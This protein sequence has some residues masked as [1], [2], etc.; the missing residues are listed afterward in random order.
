MLSFLK[1]TSNPRTQRAHLPSFTMESN[2][3]SVSFR[4]A[5]NLKSNKTSISFTLPPCLPGA[6]PKDNTIM[7][8][9]FHTHPNQVETFLVTAGTALFQLNRRLV[10]VAAGGMI[11]IPRGEYH[12]FTNA[13]SGESMTL[14]AWYDPPDLRREERFFRNLCG[15]LEDVRSEGGGML[16][17]A[18]V[19]QLALFAWEADMMMCAPN[20]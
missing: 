13:S 12:R 1:A 4:T 2:R 6:T 18:S 11:D 5:P 7:I 8:P 9:P 14:E 20:F 10:P 19:P 17:N 15:Y 16:E 3:S